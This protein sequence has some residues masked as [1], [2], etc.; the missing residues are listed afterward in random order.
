MRGRKKE[1]AD[2]LQSIHKLKLKRELSRC[3][4]TRCYRPPEIILLN[5]EYDSCVDMWSLGCILGQMLNCIDNKA[6]EESQQILFKGDSCYPIS[7]LPMSYDGSQQ[8]IS[9]NDQLFR[10]LKVLETPDELDQSFISDQ[11]TREYLAGQLSFGGN[12]LSKLDQMYKNSN[13]EL[14]KL[15]KGMLEFNPHYRL[16]ASQALQSPLF[17]SIRV[18]LYEQPSTSKIHLDIY[19]TG[20]FDYETNQCNF[21]MEELK[22]MAIREVRKIR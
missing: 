11:E 18:P 7:P 4:V 19:E 2:Q 6:V 1:I 20:S 13:P 3:V 21:T 5:Q 10:I 15:L 14:V 16:T 9:S 17:D 22:K 8:P 12:R